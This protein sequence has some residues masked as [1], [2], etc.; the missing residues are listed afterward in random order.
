MIIESEPAKSA[1]TETYD[2]RSS[3]RSSISNDVD[4]RASKQG[5]QM[6]KQHHFS[7]EKEEK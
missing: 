6:E 5:M 7:W 2:S 3:A 1:R 4:S